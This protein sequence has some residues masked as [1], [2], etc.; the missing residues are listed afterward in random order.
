MFNE[1][2]KL[3]DLKVK[4]FVTVLDKAEEAQVKGGL[5][6][7][8]GKKSNTNRYSWGVTIIDVRKDDVVLSELNGN[9]AIR[10]K[11]KG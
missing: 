9:F 4:S 3:T 2:I 10:R 1:K 8:K 6:I 5:S 11:K 7:I